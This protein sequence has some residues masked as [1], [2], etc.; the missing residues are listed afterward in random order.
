MYMNCAA[1]T[2]T[3]GGSGL[4]GPSFPDIFKANIGNGCTTDEGDL[5]FP[6][7]GPNVQG[8][9]GKPPKGN[10]GPSGSGGGSPPAASSTP[11][12]AAPTP[13]A[14]STA[15]SPPAATT[16]PT[17]PNPGNGNPAPIVPTTTT[18]ST[19][20]TPQAVAP[21]SPSSPN[22]TNPGTSCVEGTVICN[23]DGTWSQ[24]G[25]GYVQN[26]GKVAGGMVCTDGKIHSA[27]GKRA[28]RFSREHIA[29]RHSYGFV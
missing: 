8:S 14:T 5:A 12:A 3:G 26:M 7:P 21:P 16:P 13:S 18:P 22:N 20:T 29:R 24:C 2:I 11:P 19:S 4:S 6:N 10:C 17:Y 27:N 28:L 23:S 25:S 9:G 15:V 1:I